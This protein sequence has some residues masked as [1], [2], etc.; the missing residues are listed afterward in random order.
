MEYKKED[1][2]AGRMYKFIGD[3]AY[4]GNPDDKHPNLGFVIGKTY[5]MAS[6]VSDYGYRDL[7][8]DARFYIPELGASYWYEITAF[9]PVEQS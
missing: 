9:V 1:W 5:C 2:V 3:D 6:E 4:V 8:S 7:V